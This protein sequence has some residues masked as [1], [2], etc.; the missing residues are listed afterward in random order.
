MTD[1]Q[2]LFDLTPQIDEPLNKFQIVH[3]YNQSDVYHLTRQVLLDS[4]LT[5]NTYCF[6]YHILSMDIEE[7]NEQYSSFACLISRNQIEADLYLNV[8]CVAFKYIIKY[9]QTYK[10][11]G[12]EIYRENWKT[13]DEIIDLATV[14]AIPNLIT[15]LRV[16]HPSD[17]LINA[18]FDLL[19][20]YF[21]MLVMYWTKL[22]NDECNEAECC[23]Q[24]Y[25]FMEDNRQNIIDT[26]IKPYHH[27]ITPFSRDA[28]MFFIKIFFAPYI[29]RLMGMLTTPNYTFRTDD[30]CFRDPECVI[31]G[32]D[33]VTECP[34]TQQRR[35]DS[36]ECAFTPQRR[37]REESE[38]PF[39][40]PRRRDDTEC[41]FTQQR[42]RDSSE[43][44]FTQQRRRDDTECPFT[45]QRRTR[46][47]DL[48][49][50]RFIPRTGSPSS[51]LRDDVIL[52]FNSKPRTEPVSNFLR[53]PVQTTPRG[54]RCNNDNRFMQRCTST[55]RPDEHSAELKK[56]LA[57]VGSFIDACY[58]YYEL[59][60]IEK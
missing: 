16:L 35:R 58:K 19:K 7:F 52:N 60:K 39:A 32:S 48:D 3:L 22:V 14:F 42:R 41:T 34:F 30:S 28:V 47:D 36:S 59:K 49:T 10:I 31:R 44:P 43:C 25:Q 55:P 5:Q 1:N 45:Q 11:D 26:L 15:E 46:E 50:C 57:K 18:K 29:E 53:T 38:C 2:D 21:S 17:D 4:V 51:R 9:I 37:T 54:F 23:S 56:L 12:H 8:E 6:F 13:I 33:C 27:N 40:Q 24:M 20:S